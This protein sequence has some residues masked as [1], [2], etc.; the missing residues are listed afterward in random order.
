MTDANHFQFPEN[1]KQY[2]FLNY[3]QFK[4]LGRDKTLFFLPV[5]PLEVHGYHLPLNTDQL[6]AIRMAEVTAIR[7]AEANKDWMVV[8]MP[9][10]GI[11]NGT[12]PL[13]GSIEHDRESVFRV[14]YHTGK[15]LAKSGFKNIIV[16]S[17]HGGFGHNLAIDDAC[18]KICRKYGINMFAPG[19]ML[20]ENFIMGH[21]FD[22]M[23][24]ELGRPLS[25][26]ERKSLRMLEHA[27]GWETSIVMAANEKWVIGDYKDAPPFESQLNSND[28]FWIS[29]ADKFLFLLP[30]VK[31]IL[32][33]HKS[34]AR[35]LYHTVKTSSA[36]YGQKE[37]V[38]YLGAPGVASPEI[39]KAWEKVFSRDLMRLIHEV[40]IEK[41]RQANSV[42]TI[43]S[44]LFFLRREFFVTIFWVLLFAMAMSLIG[45]Y[46]L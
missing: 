7:F 26:E 16:L 46:I 31:K 34:N 20:M 37:E 35:Q 29:L 45:I 44:K 5:S 32:M 4:Q 9:V 23:E 25:A 28:H 17:G 42:Y 27:G 8:I 21:R 39:G 24:R 40:V 3:G 30:W 33:E 14:V 18:R 2:E 13:P 36:A 41:S 43:Y 11:G 12:L 22:D 38:T 15:S 10:I 19:I 1:V 6:S